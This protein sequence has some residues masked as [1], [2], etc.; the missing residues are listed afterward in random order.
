MFSVPLSTF[1]AVDVAG[2]SLQ[3]AHAS[4]QGSCRSSLSSR[5]NRELKQD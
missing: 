5:E 1:A 2:V 3:L 4:E